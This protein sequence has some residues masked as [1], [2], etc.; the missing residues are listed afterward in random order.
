M[1]LIQYYLE[2]VLANSPDYIRAQVKFTK[3][4]IRDMGMIEIV[5]LLG[6]W[7]EIE[8]NRLRSGS[9]AR[10]KRE[11][12]KKLRDMIGKEGR[13]IEMSDIIDSWVRYL[14]FNLQNGCCHLYEWK[15]KWEN[16]I[17]VFAQTFDRGRLWIKLT[18]PILLISNADVVISFYCSINS[19][20][21]Q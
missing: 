5:N 2:P 10:L 9:K 13:V 19:K 1:D 21:V 4:K 3:Q 14:L 12:E 8:E 20:I 18:C 16:G 17:N 11:K 6:K 7:K 15:G